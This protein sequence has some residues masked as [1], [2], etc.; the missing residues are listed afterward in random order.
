MKIRN[1]NDL[2]FDQLRDICSVE[3]QLILAFPDLAGKAESDGLR[4]WLLE[5][6]EKTPRQ[7]QLVL[8][9]FRRHGE[10]PGGDICKA[11]KGLIDGGNE[12]LA[13]TGDSVVRDLLLVAH[14]NRIKHYEIAAYEFATNLAASIGLSKEQGELG[15]ILDEE[16]EATRALAEIGAGLFSAAV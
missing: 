9:I 12:H 3:S 10:D 16:R 4:R 7:K 8:A 13:K 6:E 2:F 14:C 5:H 1:P 11:M 15:A